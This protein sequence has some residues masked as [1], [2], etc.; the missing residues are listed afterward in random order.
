MELIIYAKLITIYHRMREVNRGWSAT[1][2]SIVT[3]FNWCMFAKNRFDGELLY[4]LAKRFGSLKKVD[5]SNCETIST[6]TISDALALVPG[7]TDLNLAG[8]KVMPGA[9]TEALE[10]LPKI[11]RLNLSYTG[12]DD[13]VIGKICN[14]YKSNLRELRIDSC[15]VL[16]ETPDLTRLGKLEILSL[17]QCRKVVASAFGHIKQ[18][19]EL[20]ELYLVNNYNCTSRML[21]VL[22]DSLRY[23]K[24][25]E[26]GF[27]DITTELGETIINRGLDSF[28]LHQLRQVDASF[29]LRLLEKTKNYT[30]KG[31]TFDFQ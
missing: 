22:I 14:L 26:L 2:W 10:L 17:K 9:M 19:K 18:M 25:L 4:S 30:H 23:L 5:L 7:L 11:R 6:T 12:I 8:T 1:Y 29:I 31:T 15:Q 24:V 20:R 27:Y 13:R 28:A 16:L 21:K 3:S